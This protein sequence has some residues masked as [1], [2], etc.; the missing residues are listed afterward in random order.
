MKKIEFK[1]RITRE[2]VRQNRFKIFVFGDNLEEIGYGGQAKA[3]RGEYNTIG[4][5]TKQ[6]PFMYFS[7]DDYDKVKDIILAKFGIIESHLQCNHIVVLPK[8]GVGTGLARLKEKAPK[9]W[10]LIKEN[11]LKLGW[12]EN[13]NKKC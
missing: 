6:S 1:D 9:I 11:L 3:M 5:P 7:D 2:E 10:N 13:D 12:K 4:I 8:A